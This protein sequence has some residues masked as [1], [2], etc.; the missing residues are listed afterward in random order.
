M[1]HGLIYP[2]VIGTHNLQIKLN[3]I[4]NEDHSY[5]N[6]QQRASVNGQC[7]CNNICL[8]IPIREDNHSHVPE[9]VTHIDILEINRRMNCSVHIFRQQAQPF[10][11]SLSEDV[12]GVLS[13]TFYC[14]PIR[15]ETAFFNSVHAVYCIHKTD[16]H[17][18]RY[19]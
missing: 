14:S 17:A 15:I 3:Q 4:V 7:K 5:L 11:L 12:S 13:L 6:K 8:C 9:Q 10:L 2:L 18:H 1:Q 16:S 19:E